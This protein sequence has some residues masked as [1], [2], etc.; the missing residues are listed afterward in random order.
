M[1]AHHILLLYFDYKNSAKTV[2]KLMESLYS[3]HLKRE[4]LL[5]WM[6]TYGK[7]YCQKNQITFQENFEQTSGHLGMD[8]TFPRFNF[9]EA[10]PTSPTGTEKKTQVPWVYMTALPDGT[11][12]AIWEEAKTNKK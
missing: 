12:C 5:S 2:L 6:R 9:E 4:T 1:E 7:D 8:G 3:V 10:E 11:L